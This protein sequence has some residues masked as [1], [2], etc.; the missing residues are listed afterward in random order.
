[1]R[2]DWWVN[3]WTDLEVVEMRLDLNVAE[4]NCYLVVEA[5]EKEGEQEARMVS[6]LSG[7]RTSWDWGW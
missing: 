4:K 3:Q 6:R 1:M 7:G 2:L 5:E